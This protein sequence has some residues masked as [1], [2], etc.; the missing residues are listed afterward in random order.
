MR[1]YLVDEIVHSDLE[2]I[3]N[4]L[5]KNAV[6]SNLDQIFWVRIPNDLLSDIQFQHRN[7]QPYVFAVEL[8]SDW[9]K[10]EFFIRSQKSMRCTCSDY[11]TTQQGNYIIKFAQSII[12]QLDI[13]T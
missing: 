1:S 7:C 11:C 6:K 9:V 2:K 10:L 13:K 8:G 5:N 3:N 12:E 4:F